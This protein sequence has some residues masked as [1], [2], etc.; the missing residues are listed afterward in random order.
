[1]KRLLSIRMDA[2]RRVTVRGRIDWIRYVLPLTAE[3]GKR[4]LDEYT[5][6]RGVISPGW[7]AFLAVGEDAVPDMLERYWNEDSRYED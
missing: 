7:G 1:M 2:D 6:V 5:K 3:Q 4:F